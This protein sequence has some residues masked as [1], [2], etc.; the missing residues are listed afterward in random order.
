MMKKMSIISKMNE[1]NI[2][3]Y[4]PPDTELQDPVFNIDLGELGISDLCLLK[5]EE[6]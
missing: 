1:R 5:E 6:G 4:L 2:T 3:G